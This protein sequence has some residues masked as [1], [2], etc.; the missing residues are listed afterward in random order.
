MVKVVA[1]LVAVAVEGV[2]GLE[3]DDE[4]VERAAA[5]GTGLAA[6]VEA[7]EREAGLGVVAC[8]VVDSTVAEE[9]GTAVE[10]VAGLVAVAVEGVVGL[11]ADDEVVERAAATGT[12]LA[13]AV[14]AKGATVVATAAAAERAAA[15]AAVGAPS[16]ARGGPAAA[17]APHCEAR[18]TRAASPSCC[19]ASA[20]APRSRSCASWFR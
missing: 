6:A 11:E 14:E 5:A 20:A 9:M 7:V 4:V 19:G 15:A 10:L 16:P 18:R 12:G 13:A 3:A 17:R 8:W 1:G 2:V